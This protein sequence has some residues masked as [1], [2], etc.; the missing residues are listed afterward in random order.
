MGGTISSLRVAD[1]SGVTPTLGSAGLLANLPVLAEIAEVDP[2]DFPVVASYD[3]TPTDMLELARAIARSNDDGC[4]GVVVTHGTDTIEETAYALALMVERGRGVALAGA[5]RNPTMLAPEGAANLVNAFRVAAS[6][7]ARDVGPV[8]V[9]DDAV[10]AARFATK[11]H[12][13]RPSTFVSFAGQLGE[14]TEGRVDMWYRPAWDD[15]LG[16]PESL[17]GI[18]IPV[19]WVESTGAGSLLDAA[20]ELDP[21]GIVIAG[22]GGGHVPIAMLSALDGA[23]ARGITVVV[24]TRLVGGTTLESTYAMPGAEIDLSRRGALLA[25]RLSP[26]KARLRL[27][28]G[29]ALGRD[30]RRLFP[31]R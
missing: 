17:D 16:L 26:Q 21:A 24:A 20:I 27:M 11:T 1:G 14:V 19:V 15:H 7:S 12:T 29:V 25:G 10:H 2:V 30:P 18:C 6:P 4:D 31:V 23:V 5:M 13:S 9:L 8:V 28:V 3:V 22:T